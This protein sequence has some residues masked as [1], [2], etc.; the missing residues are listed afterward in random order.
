MYALTS[1]WFVKTWRK[2][3]APDSFIYLFSWE[4]NCENII[5]EHLYFIHKDVSYSVESQWFKFWKNQSFNMLTSHLT[6]LSFSLIRTLFV[7]HFS[8][9][10]LKIIRVTTAAPHILYLHSGF[11]IWIK[12]YKKV[13]MI[14]QQMNNASRLV[15]YLLKYTKKNI[16]DLYL[17]QH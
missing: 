16:P 6:C 12:R 9:L 3:E 7:M 2:K 17:S 5:F 13:N 10:R 11:I 15:S 1:F 14:K 8:W 4:T